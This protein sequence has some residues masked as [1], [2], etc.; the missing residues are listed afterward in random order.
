MAGAQ[1]FE[2]A[3]DGPSGMPTANADALFE[4]LPKEM[5]RLFKEVESYVS[6]ISKEWS[7]T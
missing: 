5:L 4:D 2:S 7:E 6:R 1:N 3:S